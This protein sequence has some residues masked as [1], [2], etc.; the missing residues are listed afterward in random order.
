MTE[1]QSV[2]LMHVGRIS[3]EICNFCL[4][5]GSS[6]YQIINLFISKLSTCLFYMSEH[7]YF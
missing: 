4:P 6:G 2:E 3:P 7:V 1:M 5:S